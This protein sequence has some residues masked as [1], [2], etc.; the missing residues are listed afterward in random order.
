MG[1]HC[2][3]TANKSVSFYKSHSKSPLQSTHWGS[4]SQMG[5]TVFPSNLGLQLGPTHPNTKGYA[6]SPFPAD[7]SDDP[8]TLPLLPQGQRPVI[9]KIMEM[10]DRE[11]G[12]QLSSPPISTPP[13]H[14]HTQAGG[15][16]G[17]TGHPQEKGYLTCPRKGLGKQAGNK[18][19][20]HFM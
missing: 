7:G 18:R 11:T 6:V 4:W 15:K 10:E 2:R 1:W 12:S 20:T 14:A 3:E 5:E 16:P 19:K 8:H 17:D 13:Q 9:Q